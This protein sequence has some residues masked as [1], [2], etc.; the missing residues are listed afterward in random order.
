MKKGKLF[1]GWWI[2]VAVFFI[3]AYA[4]GVI[5]YSFTA[6]FEPIAKDLNLSYAQVSFA[7]SIR[8]FETSFLGPLVG[9]LFDR[10]GPRKL[11]FAGA[12]IIGLG[13]LLLSRADSI[14]TF[15]FSFFLMAMGLSSCTGFILTSVVGN[16]FRKKVTT[17]MGIALCGGAV[18]G[19]LVPLVT[20]LIDVLEWRMA[21]VVMGLAA[22][23]VLLPL[24][25]LVRHKPEQYGY[26]PDGDEM[27]E[28]MSTEVLTSPQNTEMNTGVRQILKNRAFW[29]I[30][31]GFLTHYLVISSVITH[32]MPYL[33]S[34]NVPRSSSSLVASGIPLA[35]IMGRLTF[36]WF[37]DRF[38]KRRVVA[39]GFI[40][41]I[42]GLLLLNYIDTIGM[43][44]LVPFVIIFGVGFGGPVPLALSMLLGY[45]GRA[46]SSTI[47]GLLMGV[48]V[49]GSIVGP[50]LAGWIFDNYG[51]YQIAW[52]AFVGITIVGMIMLITAP[53]VNG[54]R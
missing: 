13:L 14:A 17:V 44:I 37:G 46:R 21:M 3:S 42:L 22:W 26:L 4:N 18:G 36:G 8:G 10:Y 23:C 28:P 2:V 7:A 5:F 1:Y 48:V 33:S 38:D 41:A 29:L 51:S 27:I 53:P 15:Y 31:L 50:P 24:S 43:W 47:I 11:I 9:F 49:I 20:Q 34:I 54:V 35:S 30:S 39:I 45:F 19:L 32:I 25:L 40:L 6:I 52:F 12:V 16:W